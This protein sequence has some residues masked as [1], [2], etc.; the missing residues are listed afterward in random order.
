M[1]YKGK[2]KILA[3]NQK[4]IEI[5]TDNYDISIMR[6]ANDDTNFDTIIDNSLRAKKW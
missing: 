6:K 4:I 1:I 3:Q 5:Q 2:L